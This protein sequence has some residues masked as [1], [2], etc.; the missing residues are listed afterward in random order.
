MF[1]WLIRLFKAIIALFTGGSKSSAP[2]PVD[3]GPIPTQTGSRVAAI[4][5]SL[6]NAVKIAM[7]GQRPVAVEIDFSQVDTADLDPGKALSD[8]RFLQNFMSNH[9]DQAKELVANITNVGRVQQIVQQ[10]GL[11]SEFQQGNLI[12][13]AITLARLHSVGTELR[14]LGPNEVPATVG[15]RTYHP[16][17]RL[18]HQGRAGDA[19]FVGMEGGS[20]VSLLGKLVETREVVI[21]QGMCL[22][23]TEML[24]GAM[25]GQSAQFNEIYQVFHDDARVKSIVYDLGLDEKTTVQR[26]GGLACACIVLVIFVVALVIIWIG[27]SSRAAKAEFVPVD[28]TDTLRRLAA[29]PIETWSYR[30][31]GADTRHIGPMAEDF[32]SAFQVGED[33]RYIAHIDANGVAFAAIQG[34]N[35]VLEEKSREIEELK[36]RLAALEADIDR[37]DG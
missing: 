29:L 5:A 36:L 12:T 35:S 24:E 30:G 26:G 10:A 20:I 34:L 31:D 2:T 1:G 28:T 7:D 8:V 17:E 37:T 18:S 9:P 11:E 21:E 3:V 22:A 27:L 19:E 25:D 6:Q 14:N 13:G 23:D 15:S 33:N 4:P 32:H 16:L